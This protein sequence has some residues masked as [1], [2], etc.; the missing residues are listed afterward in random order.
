MQAQQRVNVAISPAG[1][2]WHTLNCEPDSVQQRPHYVRIAIIRFGGWGVAYLLSN[3]KGKKY[4]RPI[5]KVQWAVP[6]AVQGAVGVVPNGFPLEVGAPSLD[7]SGQ[8]GQA[9]APCVVRLHSG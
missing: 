4:Y 8:S 6:G 3:M 5:L 2:E 1:M 7:A 9:F